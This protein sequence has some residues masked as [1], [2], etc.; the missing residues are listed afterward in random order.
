MKFIKN[1]VEKIID[2]PIEEHWSVIPLME[3][4]PPGKYP[5][6][7]HSK[8]LKNGQYQIY[9]FKIRSDDHTE[10][11]KQKYDADE[12]GVDSYIN[13]LSFLRMMA[14][15]GYC[16]AVWRYG[17]HNIKPYVVPAILGQS[18]DILFW[19]G[20]DGEQI[21]YQESKNMDTDHVVITSQLP[22]GDIH[23]RVKL[24]SKSLVPEYLVIVG[25][26]TDGVHGLYQSLGYN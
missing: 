10:Y 12:I 1:G 20:S 11:L 16:T 21:V 7:A 25:R 8:G 5:S 14:K 26:L 9:G 17:L 2:V 22:N 15:I 19:V 3:I 13:P 4:G 18:D 23:A 24:F 6:L